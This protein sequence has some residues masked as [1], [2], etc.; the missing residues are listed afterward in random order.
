MKRILFICLLTLRLSGQSVA[1]NPE[2]AASILQTYNCTE[3][4]PAMQWLI[5]ETSLPGMNQLS[6]ASVYSLNRQSDPALLQ[7]PKFLRSKETGE[8]LRNIQNRNFAAIQQDTSGSE[9][10]K[11]IPLRH[12][13]VSLLVA[14]KKYI[15]KDTT[16][17]IRA[18]YGKLL[19]DTS[20]F[21]C[22]LTEINEYSTA[23]CKT[24]LT[25]ALQIL[26]ETHRFF[27]KDIET[28]Q[29]L[30]EAYEQA[31]DTYLAR[32]VYEETLALKPDGT[33]TYIILKKIASLI[34]QD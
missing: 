21:Y 8:N 27:P 33:L 30:A 22:N 9:W 14:L 7:A 34:K 19:K 15:E 25:I 31:G 3:A 29:L 2:K 12:R 18:Y 20:H 11:D 16:A 6:E 17:D 32:Q 24:G 28:T 4:N 5:P 1:A 10:V 23:L 26:N 13:K